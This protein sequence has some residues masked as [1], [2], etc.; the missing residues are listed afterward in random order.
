MALIS[1]NPL[2]INAFG[3]LAYARF[4]LRMISKSGLGSILAHFISTERAISFKYLMAT[5]SL[6]VSKDLDPIDNCSL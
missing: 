6:T 4:R 3:S 2:R 5:D 1:L